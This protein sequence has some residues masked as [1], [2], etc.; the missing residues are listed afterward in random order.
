[1]PVPFGLMAFID[2]HKLKNIGISSIYIHLSRSLTGTAEP[3]GA[4]GGGGGPPTFIEETIFAL[5]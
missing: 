1:M 5:V 3:R 2:M 4:V